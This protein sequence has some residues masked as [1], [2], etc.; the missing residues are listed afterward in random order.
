VAT[1]PVT[2]L[3]ILTVETVIIRATPM[4]AMAITTGTIRV[5]LATVMVPAMVTATVTVRE[6]ATELEMDTTMA[7]VVTDRVIT[8]AV[9]AVM[10]T[11]VVILATVV[12]I[13]ATVAATAVA[14]VAVTD[15]VSRDML[16]RTG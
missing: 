13:L 2:T 8:P 4:V 9:T 1:I 16:M 15:T 11:V 5:A 6:L 10:A 12:V 3:D 14:M 7:P